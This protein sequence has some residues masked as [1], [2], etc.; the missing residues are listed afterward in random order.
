MR[1]EGVWGRGWVGAPNT[2]MNRPALK[3]LF[4]YLL[5]GL[6]A[7]YFLTPQN[8]SVSQ[9]HTWLFSAL[10]ATAG[11]IAYKTRRTYSEQIGSVL[12]AIAL[13]ALGCFRYQSAIYSPI[14]PDLYNQKVRFSGYVTHNLKES[15]LEDETED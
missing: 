7:C 10:F 11:G 12:F 13:F 8:I 15:N 3:A 5:G 14:P 4:P 2:E 1:G 9:F 6:F